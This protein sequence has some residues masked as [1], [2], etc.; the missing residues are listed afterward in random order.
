MLYRKIWFYAWLLLLFICILALDDVSPKT[1]GKRIPILLS[2]ALTTDPWRGWILAFSL[3]AVGSSFY[4]NSIIMV[5]GFLGFMCAFLVSMFETNAHDAL[6]F[7]S[8]LCIMYECYPRNNNKWWLTHWWFT[9]FCGFIC[10]IWLIYADYVC[11]D[12]H[13]SECSWWYVTEYL[14]F[15]SMFLLI[16]WR[17][18][19]D[20]Q[21]HDEI[22]FVSQN[23]GENVPMIV[24]K[25]SYVKENKIMF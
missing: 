1:C 6:I 7:V 20:E 8:S 16:T 2:R 25:K 3:L 17:I 21:L 22:R 13:C 15:W 18:P 9:F 5:T 24:K 12:N 11:T 10:L 14:A 23:S 19:L 4:L